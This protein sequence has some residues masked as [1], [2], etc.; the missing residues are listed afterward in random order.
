MNIINKYRDTSVQTK[1][2]L[3]YMICNI[4]QKGI[5]FIIVPI[6]TRLLTTYEYG[7]YTVFQSWRDLL[8]II[9]TL[10][11]YCGVFTKAMVDYKD[12]RDRYTSSMQG[13]TT[14]LVCIWLLIYLIKIEFWNNL[15]DMETI[16]MLLMFLYFLFSVSFSFWSVKQRVTYKYKTMVVATLTMSL[17]VPLL[18]LIL[19]K[20]TN[21]RANAVIWGFLI[22]QSLVG[23][24]FYIIQFIQGKCFYHKEY[25]IYAL[26]FN[27]PLIPH[28]LSLIVLSQVD[29]IMIKNICGADKAGI[30][31]LAYSVSLLMNILTSA[32]NNS[33][34]P[35]FYEKLRDKEYLAIKPIVNKLCMLVAV[36]TLAAI[37]ISPEIVSILGTKDYYE[38]IYIIPAVS[39]SVY[40]TFCYSFYSN[41]EFYYSKTKFVMIASTVGA[42][43]NL[44]LNY[45]FINKYGYQAAGYTTLISYIVLMI[46]HYCFMESICKNEISNINVFDDKCMFGLTALLIL[47]MFI[48]LFLYDY[49]VIRYLVIIV[50][51]VLLLIYRKKIIALIKDMK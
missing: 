3:W 24:F 12:D 40:I 33:F 38:A 25:W 21:L 14:I 36:L 34:V 16:T 22:A 9:V 2:T 8:I 19:L 37:L 26:K 45:I 48:C 31:G 46:M 41:I 15:F 51:F 23:L 5:S 44:I 17:L 7:Q 43:S 39:I 49:F 29:R 4:L 10:N 47:I 18:S 27:I 20:Y 32:V 13:L 28:Y 35:W 1:A 6:Y 50:I 11:L 42:V 30:Y